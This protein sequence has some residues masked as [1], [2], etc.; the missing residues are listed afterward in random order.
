M[1]HS[2]QAAR[3]H[4]FAMACDIGGT[5]TDFVLVDTESGRITTAKVLSNANS[6]EETV[7]DGIKQLSTVNGDFLWDTHPVTHGTTLAINALI[8]RRGPVVGMLATDGFRDILEMR[9]G[10][11]GDM[12]DISGHLPLPLVP[13]DLRFDIPE[14]VASDGTVVQNVSQEA[15]LAACEELRDAG[16][17]AIAVCFLHSFMNPANENAAA[18]VAKVAI[19]S[20]AIACSSVVL[21]VPGEWVRFSATI[22]NAYL[23]P[24]IANYLPKLRVGL[25]ARGFHGSDLRLLTSEGSQ[26]PAAL[27]LEAPVRFVESGPVGGVLAAARSA[28]G[29]DLPAAIALDIGGTTA[30]SALIEKNAPLPLN[31]EYEVAREYRF[32]RG[33]GIPLNV[34]SVDLLEIGAGGGSVASVGDLGLVQ[35]GPRSAGSHPGPAVYGLGG[36]EPTLTDADV[37]LGLIDPAVFGTGQK[38][39]QL[40]WSCF[41]G[42]SHRLGVAPQEV[43]LRVR[44]VALA[45]MAAAIQTQLAQSGIDSGEIAIVAYGGAGPLYAADIAAALGIR[46]VLIPPAAAVFSALGMVLAPAAYTS[47]RALVTRRDAS[48]QSAALDA[49]WTAAEEE[50]ATS[51]GSSRDDTTLNYTYQVDARYRGQGRPLTVQI[52]AQRLLEPKELRQRFEAEYGQRFGANHPDQEFELVGVRVTVTRTD[53]RFAKIDLQPP[54]SPANTPARSGTRELFAGTAQRCRAQVLGRSSLSVHTKVDGPALID[55]LG[56]TVYVPATCSASVDE[57]CNLR[58]VIEAATK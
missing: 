41:G 32:A 19:P 40:A 6:P 52:G 9:D 34:P 22:A 37:V 39:H 16:A 26:C 28:N 8:E 44:G 11:R 43:A 24:V 30:K 12:W 25:Y 15:V 21:P 31:E 13:R 3:P 10:T 33:S 57:R 45:T 47:L 18:R 2:E 35:V 55:D 23:M 1:T 56:T 42:L 49:A 20:A 58:M 38:G 17:E 54:L 48:L 14:R 36:T 29:A 5:F 50:A 7:F 27:A 46:H 51:V 4:R 53:Q